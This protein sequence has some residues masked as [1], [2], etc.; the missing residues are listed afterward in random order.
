MQAPHHSIRISIKLD[1]EINT[2]LTY[3][4]TYI[5]SLFTLILIDFCVNFVSS[6]CS[7]Q[8]LL[9]QWRTKAFSWVWVTLS[10]TSQ[11][12]LTIT[13]CKSMSHP[14]TNVNSFT[15][16]AQKFEIFV[17]VFCFAFLNF[18]NVKQY[19]HLCFSCLILYLLLLMLKLL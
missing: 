9:I 18:C 5:P 1:L 15:L 8:F 4:H 7:D 17:N 3:I 11:Q 19:K 6:L 14:P 16:I 10:S 13:S 12:L 2:T